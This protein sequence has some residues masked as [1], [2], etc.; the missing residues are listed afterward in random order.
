MCDYATYQVYHIHFPKSRFMSKTVFFINSTFTACGFR[1]SSRVSDR[2][3]GPIGVQPPS[4]CR[5]SA[6]PSAHKIQDR[7]QPRVLFLRLRYF[8]ICTVP[9]RRSAVRCDVKLRRLQSCPILRQQLG[10]ADQNHAFSV[11]AGAGRERYDP[12]DAVEID[13]C[14][15]ER[16]AEYGPQIRPQLRRIA[17]QLIRFAG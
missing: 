15:Y 7:V 9:D 11:Y 8:G 6:A 3:F 10:D 5:N 12:G 16:A 1:S 17:V 4:V 14:G 2:F 13:R